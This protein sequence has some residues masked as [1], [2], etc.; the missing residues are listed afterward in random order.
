MEDEERRREARKEVEEVRKKER[1][2]REKKRGC[3]VSWGGN[4]GEAKV[5]KRINE[6]EFGPG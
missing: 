1:R 4:P 3:E 2:E 5:T 6:S